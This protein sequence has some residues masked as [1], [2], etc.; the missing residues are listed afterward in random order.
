MILDLFTRKMHGF[1]VL[2]IIKESPEWQDIPVLIYSSK[3]G[4]EI[5]GKVQAAG[6]AE[7]LLTMM[8]SPTKLAEIVKK[9]LSPKE[10]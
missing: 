2:T 4:D 9:I 5:T 6:A 7:F 3:G 8:T 10:W 1:K